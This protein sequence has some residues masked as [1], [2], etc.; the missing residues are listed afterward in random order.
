M[1]NTMS[2]EDIFV[3]LA[4]GND[5]DSL[6]LNSCP[7][8]LNE[9]LRDKAERLFRKIRHSKG[10]GDDGKKEFFRILNSYKTPMEFDNISMMLTCLEK[11]KNFINFI[12]CISRSHSAY[13]VSNG[14]AAMIDSSRAFIVNS[15]LDLALRKCHTLF[16]EVPHNICAF[17]GITLYNSEVKWLKT[18]GKY[19]FSQ[20]EVGGKKWPPNFSILPMAQYNEIVSLNLELTFSENKEFVGVCDRCKNPRTREIPPFPQRPVMCLQSLNNS[21]LQN[22]PPITLFSCIRK[23]LAYNSEGQ[24]SS[25]GY[26]YD[27]IHGTQTFSLNIKAIHNYS[28]L[29][30]MFENTNEV[31]STSKVNLARQW[32]LENNFVY[33]NMHMKE[34]VNFGKAR[35]NSKIKG[36]W[37]L[38]PNTDF[39][40][41]ITEEDFSQIRLPDLLFTRNL[42]I[43]GRRMLSNDNSLFELLLFPNLF[44]L[45]IPLENVGTN[46]N[47]N[48][49][50]LM[51]F[52]DRKFA[53]NST[54]IFSRYLRIEK[55]R[56]FQ[57]GRRITYSDSIDKKN[58]LSIY[59][60]SHYS[61]S[62]I[63]DETK[64]NPIPSFIRGGITY[65][66]RRKLDVQTVLERSSQD[67][68]VFV[69]YS[70]HE[71]G[72][73]DL[74]YF[75]KNTPGDGDYH[76]RFVDVTRH[77]MQRWKV[78]KKHI[79]LNCKVNGIGNVKD[80][81][82]R[83]EF[84]KRG[85][86]HTHGMLVPGKT[87][88]QMMDEDVIS[89]ELPLD[90]ALLRLVLKYQVHRH[91]EKICG[92]KENDFTTVCKKGFPAQNSSITF[93]DSK[94]KRFVYKRTTELSRWISP[95]IAS[96]LACWKANMNAQYCTPNA[97]TSYVT[98]YC[99][100][101]E[102][103]DNFEILGDRG[104][105]KEF[106]SGRALSSCEAALHLSGQSVS[107]L[108]RKVIYLDLNIE[109]RRTRIVRPFKEVKE[110]PHFPF[111]YHAIEKYYARPVHA[112]FN[113]LT[114]IEFYE[115]YDV[116]S[117]P[118][119]SRKIGS[120]SK[121]KG[122][123]IPRNGL[124]DELS[125]P[126]IILN[127]YYIVERKDS[128]YARFYK[129]DMSDGEQ[130]FFQLLLQQCP[131]R[132]DDELRGKHVSF[133][134]AF[135][136]KYPDVKITANPKLV[137][138]AFVQEKLELVIPAYASQTIEDQ[139]YHYLLGQSKDVS[140]KLTMTQD[141]YKAFETILQLD[142]KLHFITGAP[143]TGKTALI[144]F[145][146]DAKKK[147]GKI[148]LLAPTGTAAISI[149]GK[150]F[151]SYFRLAGESFISN[152]SKKD[153][154]MT[155]STYI[156]DEV[157]MMSAELL[158]AF[159]RYLQK[160]HNSNEP[161]GGR[162]VIL[163]GD[164]FQLA[165]VKGDLAFT[166]TMF[167]LFKWHVLREQVRFTGSLADKF[168]EILSL[169][170]LG[171]INEMVKSFLRRV[172]ESQY[173]NTTRILCTSLF[174]RRQ[175]A[176]ICN[177]KCIE[178]LP[179]P[180]FIFDAEDDFKLVEKDV[181]SVCNAQKTIRLKVGMRVMFIRNDF[182]NDISNGTI[183]IVLN[184]VQGKASILYAVRD[185]V[186]QITIYH[187]T[188]F[189]FTIHGVLYSRLQFPIIPAFGLTVHKAQGKTLNFMMLDLNK[190]YFAPGQAY[191]ALSRIANVEN[192]VIREL[193]F[194]CFLVNE[195]VLKLYR[196]HDAL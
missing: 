98:K 51:K 55:K 172:Q 129:S 93:F 182:A 96:H 112:R 3:D 141:Q 27:V 191:V 84:Q 32:L 92:V 54:F 80:Y 1:S 188:R 85:A 121:K 156:V 117:I 14:I 126:F 47:S 50:Y 181:Q 124:R 183:G 194:S 114:I 116:K 52:A 16:C 153:F 145:L 180:I 64:T 170:R 164:F 41:E 101:P 44:P 33:S 108:S 136:H 105:I 57:N 49:K 48:T 18:R 167:D 131:C 81:F 24:P 21:E 115:I 120:N 77:Y 171:N 20:I 13:Q 59:R 193:D 75:L 125:S 168:K 29:I 87:V 65:W 130:Y 6:S 192:L 86:I 137:N 179:G 78:F 162:T 60:K 196:Q 109:S 127:N 152:L 61:E 89:A 76:T 2:D 155:I 190:S 111:Y 165:P 97:T 30:G 71:R 17:C 161:F 35:I 176:L 118:N 46:L 174:S 140:C 106:L 135:R 74:Q 100:K 72:W 95:Y 134:S 160:I 99:T 4:Y 45:G 79:M 36:K 62:M 83:H 142:C 150:T 169:I 149:D 133:F 8:V 37:A 42:G 90:H 28:G 195:D 88:K 187:Q 103:S 7:I 146:M 70:S 94:K 189:R 25:L 144:F 68:N 184:I 10:D 9:S 138:D 159:N 104:E 19:E 166:S 12:P 56:L 31:V 157:S 148:A 73:D 53:Q 175:D 39:D 113:D 173:L 58:P 147:L 143:G 67:V 119:I 26:G 43:V 132:S 38:L 163:V 22:L 128:C 185:C 40:N 91:S 186:K 66:E 63:P 177:E 11:N 82:Y 154:D 151:H 110:D 5:D 107:R 178:D 122:D 69:T 15:E 34:M 123:K 158:N 102:P 23:G 139:I